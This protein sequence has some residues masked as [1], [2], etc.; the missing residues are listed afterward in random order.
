[1]IALTITYTI[2]LDI[3]KKE[4]NAANLNYAFF[5]V[6]FKKHSDFRDVKM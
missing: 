2:I 3:T 5:F 1:M 6:D 4:K